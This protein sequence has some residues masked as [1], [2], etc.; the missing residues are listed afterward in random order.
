MISDFYDPQGP[1]YRRYNLESRFDRDEG[2]LV[3]PLA[4]AGTGN[5]TDRKVIRVHAPVAYRVVDWDILKDGS[6]PLIPAHITTP[7]GDEPLA[8]SIT[9]VMPVGDSQ[10][11]FAYL[12]RGRYTY[13]QPSPRGSDNDA[14]LSTGWYPFNQELIV[15]QLVGLLAGGLAAAVLDNMT[16]RAE[17]EANAEA[18][19]EA[20]FTTKKESFRYYSSGYSAQLF[21]GDLIR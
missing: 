19:A 13:V 3:L 4:V 14:T 8:S 11:S 6:P 10:T 9:A 15:A 21:S 7:S 2:L 1:L 18:K 17:Q 12:M 5:P 16:T 20:D